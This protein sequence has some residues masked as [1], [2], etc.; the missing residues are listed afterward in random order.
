MDYNHQFSRRAESY[1]SA[2]SKYPDVLEKELMCAIH[3][4][5]LRHGE[6]LLVIPSS[7]EK[8]EK[9][10]PADLKIKYKAFETNKELAELTNTAQ[11]SFHS[12]P[13][14]NQS[15][16]TMLSLASLHHCTNEERIQFYKEAKRVLK[17]GGKLVIGDVI[18]DSEQDKWLNIFVNMH[19]PLGHIGKFWTNEDASLMQSC[20]FTV[21]TSIQEYT[22]DFSDKKAMYDFV[23]RLF[24]IH[25]A[26]DEELSDGLTNYL[27]A[28]F[29][30]HGFPWKLLYFTA[31][32]P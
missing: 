16:D 22:W 31:S 4:C 19:N 23:R 12:I 5:N 2:L 30:N 13:Y 3:Q 15:V 8:I 32:L 1:L 6:T 11:C 26:S 27:H 7:C 20:G 21:A 29:E 17:P 24:S 18:Q 10:I 28:D 25:S 14:T 9:Y